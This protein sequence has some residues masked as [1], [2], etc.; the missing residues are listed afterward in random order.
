M[1]FIFTLINVLVYHFIFDYIKK[2]I[3]LI[4][5]SFIG[6]YI[7]IRGLSIGIGHFPD[8]RLVIAMVSKREISQLNRVFG[9]AFIF[10]FL[11]IMILWVIGMMTQ[12]WFAQ[13]LDDFKEGSPELNVKVSKK[14][15][16]RKKKEGEEQKDKLKNENI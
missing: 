2:N 9:N 6:A 14:R 8:E 13:Q 16:E 7:S 12:W 1:I 5:T 15:G 4:S 3:I 10:Y 11:T